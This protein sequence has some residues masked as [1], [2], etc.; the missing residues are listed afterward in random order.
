MRRALIEPMV[1][2]FVRRTPLRRL[3]ALKNDDLSGVVLPL[4]GGLRV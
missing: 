1:A 2:D 3:V 4:G